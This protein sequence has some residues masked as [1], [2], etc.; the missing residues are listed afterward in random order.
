MWWSGSPSDTKE[1]KAFKLTRKMP[2]S[3][4]TVKKLLKRRGRSNRK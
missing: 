4:K 1:A 3:G 2:K